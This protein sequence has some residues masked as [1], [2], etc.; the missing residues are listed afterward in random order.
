MTLQELANLKN[1]NDDDDDDNQ[2]KDETMLHTTIAM[3]TNYKDDDLDN[4]NDN[5][6]NNAKNTTKQTT[7]QVSLCFYY[8]YC[9]LLAFSGG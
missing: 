7:S 6:D 9:T 8:Y 4:E 1:D 5:Y 3:T 2:I